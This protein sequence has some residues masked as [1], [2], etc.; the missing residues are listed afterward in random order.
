MDGPQ[1]S[2][3]QPKWVEMAWP[4]QPHS[5]APILWN[6]NPS[7]K[8]LYSSSVLFGFNVSGLKFYSEICP[9][10]MLRSNKE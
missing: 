10:E 1:A 5:E 2:F 9:S 3:Q 6:S 7:F 4:P 8:M